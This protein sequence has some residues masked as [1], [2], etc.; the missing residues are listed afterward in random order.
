MWLARFN[1][2]ET[3]VYLGTT[4]LGVRRT[5]GE[6]MWCERD[7]ANSLQDQ[8]VSM[9]AQDS[10][11]TGR[12]RVWMSGALARPF[13]IHSESGA[14]SYKERQMIGEVL[15]RQSGAFAGDPQVWIEPFR[16][17]SSGLCVA[18]DSSLLQQLHDTARATGLSLGS[19]RPAWNPVLDAQQ[20]PASHVSAM[21]RIKQKIQSWRSVQDQ[22]KDLARPARADGVSEDKVWSLAEPDAL[23]LM[24]QRDHTCLFVETFE[25]SELDPGWKLAVRRFLAIHGLADPEQSRFVWQRRAEKQDTRLLTT[26]PANIPIGSI[27]QI[28]EQNNP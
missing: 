22:T 28:A 27:E 23:T 17:H 18:T 14:Q 8:L 1:R 16:Y 4:L 2:F 21:K 24:V 3:E 20:M 15:A 6:T 11:D 10:P 9:L 13:V 26:H 19:V 7:D 5:Q 12:M 25:Y